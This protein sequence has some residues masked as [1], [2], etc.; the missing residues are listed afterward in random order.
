MSTDIEF[1]IDALQTS[2]SVEVQVRFLYAS[3]ALEY[4]A[5][6]SMYD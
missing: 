5:S 1:I 6:Y 4:S 2:S 3:F